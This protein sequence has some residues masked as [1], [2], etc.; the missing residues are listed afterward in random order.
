MTK[1]KIR[2]IRWALTLSI[3]VFL[4]LSS[5]QTEAWAFGL[6]APSIYL[7]NLSSRF[8]IPTLQARTEAPRP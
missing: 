2:K 7:L 4:G 5:V 8:M 6:S 3:A 1:S